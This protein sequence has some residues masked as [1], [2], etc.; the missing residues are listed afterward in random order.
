MASDGISG[1]GAQIGR[2]NAGDPLGQAHGYL[3]VGVGEA[4]AMPLG[5]KPL[6]R[7][8]VARGHECSHHLSA[9]GDQ[10]GRS[11]FGLATESA[12]RA[13]PSTAESAFGIGSSSLV[14]MAK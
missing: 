10:D 4:M 9:S 6:D 12:S 7:L 2:E 8:E 5:V 13:S 11:V 1:H 3:D 14:T